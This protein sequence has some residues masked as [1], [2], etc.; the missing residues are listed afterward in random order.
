MV[1]AEPSVRSAAVGS[2]HADR[3]GY[4]SYGLVGSNSHTQARKAGPNQFEP[5]SRAEPEQDSPLAALCPDGHWFQRIC[6]H[7]NWKY[8]YKGC[9]RWECA[10]CFERKLRLELVPEIVE[11]LKL[12]RKRRVTLKHLVLTWPGDDLG[13][14]PTPE[15][16]KRRSKDTAH[17]FQWFR[18]RGYEVDYLRVAETHKRGTVHF[19][20]LAIMPGV[21][22]GELRKQ[23][24]TYS[25]GARMLRLDS[26][27]EKCPR[28]W[29]EG[30]PA[31]KQADHKI[32]H[33]PGKG[34]C[35]ACGY[36]PS[37]SDGLAVA[38]AWEAGKYLSKEASARGIV[39][40]LTRS[41][42]WPDYKAIAKAEADARGSL[43]LD[44][45][46]GKD[47][48]SLSALGHEYEK[49]GCKCP[50]CRIEHLCRYVGTGLMV[51]QDYPKLGTVGAMAA[52]YYPT[53]GGPC[54][55]FGGEGADWR[56]STADKA[57]LGLDEYRSMERHA[58][59]GPRDYTGPMPRTTLYLEERMSR[60]K[61]LESEHGQVRG[62]N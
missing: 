57:S 28:C 17:L 56:A 36:K 50:G 26:C 39:K 44:C 31:S 33:W 5:E 45:D 25:G 7:G 30:V 8:H 16:A 10:V 52:V 15:G 38:I 18:R 21:D 3:H 29:E 13:A 55:C 47:A 49:R 11:A 46:A 59:D 35:A 2:G 58:R 1:L 9:E 20:Y 22:V 19:H 54:R 6:G 12:A 62:G 51:K 40:K 60:W 34:E 53:G 23:W 48:H 43:C 27:F 61:A 41:K 42:Y 32:V 4:P 24:K 14:Q 37:S